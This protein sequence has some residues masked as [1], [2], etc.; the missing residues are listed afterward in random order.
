[1]ETKYSTI[2]D[3]E[4]LWIIKL[5]NTLV[6]GFPVEGGHPGRASLTACWSPYSVVYTT[7]FTLG[8]KFL[9]N[10]IAFVSYLLARDSAVA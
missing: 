4:Y 9:K 6:E 10:E 5:S 2:F 7:S 8:T 3:N 1:M